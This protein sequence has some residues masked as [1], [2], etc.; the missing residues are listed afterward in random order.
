MCLIS[1]VFIINF[2]VI[3]AGNPGKV[4]VLMSTEGNVAE[5][6]GR[7]YGMKASKWG[8]YYESVYIGIS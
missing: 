6:E 2:L 3:Y 5:P 8:G 1:F 7:S 4:L